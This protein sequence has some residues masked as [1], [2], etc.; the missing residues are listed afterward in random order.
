MTKKQQLDSSDFLGKMCVY[1]NGEYY[2]EFEYDN[3][4][5]VE[6]YPADAPFVVLNVESG[7]NTGYEEMYFFKILCYDGRIGKF[8]T[9]L[10]TIEI[11]KYL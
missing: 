6:G 2:L 11:V 1:T 9:T 7:K 8:R 5:N 3:Y 4:F 10:G